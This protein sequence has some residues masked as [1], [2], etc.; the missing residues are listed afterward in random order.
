MLKFTVVIALVVLTFITPC[1]LAADENQPED[2]L[3][4]QTNAFWSARLNLESH[5]AIV[6]G[7]DKTLPA[8]IESWREHG[9][10][11]QVMTG[12]SWG[13]YKDY[14]EG[15]F[16]G[17]VHDEEGQTTRD[18]RRIMHGI[19]HGIYYICPTDSYSRYLCVGVQRALDAGAQAIY[20]EEPEFWAKG[21]YSGS[22][23]RA[24]KDYYHE[25]W[26]PPHSSVDA[27]YRASKLKYVLLFSGHYHKSFNSCMNT[28]KSMAPRSA[29]TCLPTRC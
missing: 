18:G 3:S 15:R 14:L 12:V 5:V 29:A 4:F 16:D 23:K 27:Q 11:I 10:G 20:L 7:I 6:Y 26:L 19:G 17:I 13:A 25:D 22:F 2:R 1:I 8:R 21:G 9:Y 28:T 24:W